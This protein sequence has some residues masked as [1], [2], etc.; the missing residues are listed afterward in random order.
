MKRDGLSSDHQTLEAIGLMVVGRVRQ[1]E[2]LREKIEQQFARLQQMPHLVRSFFRA[3]SVS[4]YCRL[5]S[6]FVP[7]EFG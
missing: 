3:P 2:E 7:V 1:G 5:P 6:I 4:Q